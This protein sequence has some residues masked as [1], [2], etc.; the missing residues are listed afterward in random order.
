MATEYRRPMALE[1][2]PEELAELGIKFPPDQEAQ[3]LKEM[4]EA[5]DRN[6][7]KAV[8]RLIGYWRASKVAY[9]SGRDGDEAALA[10][11]LSYL[12]DYPGV[13][14]D[15]HALILGDLIHGVLY[16]KRWD[17][18]KSIKQW[19]RNGKPDTPER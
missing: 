16:F 19:E 14:D 2:T 3:V 15:C 4:S 1:I 11:L 10:L 18:D 5:L 13:V 8:D 12:P 9:I 7:G 17:A 6:V